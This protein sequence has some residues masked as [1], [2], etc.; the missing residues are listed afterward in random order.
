MSYNAFM[1]YNRNF[2]EIMDQVNS[3]AK[4]MGYTNGVSWAYQQLEAKCLNECNFG[5]F[6]NCHDLKKLL[7]RGYY[8]DISIT[9]STLQKARF[10]LGVIANPNNL[11]YENQNQ[12]FNKV[13]PDKQKDDYEDDLPF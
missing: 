10:F 9:Y 7:D 5:Y 2:V 13:E 11:K 1:S 12:L 4:S 6:N 8:N 3:I